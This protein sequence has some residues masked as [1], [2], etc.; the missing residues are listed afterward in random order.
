MILFSFLPNPVLLL[1]AGCLVQ[2][3]A[4]AWHRNVMRDAILCVAVL[5]VALASLLVPTVFVMTGH[6]P[7]DQ[8][9]PSHA[10]TRPRP[11][12]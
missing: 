11:S 5:I 7:L 1:C 4:I 10:P 12:A 9:S 8:H 2:L 6:L 3:G